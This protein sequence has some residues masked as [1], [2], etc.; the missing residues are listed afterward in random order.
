MYLSR[1]EHMLFD[2]AHCQLDKAYSRDLKRSAAR[3]RCERPGQLGRNLPNRGPSMLRLVHPAPVGQGSRALGHR[4]ASCPSL[5]AHEWHHFH[6]ALQNSPPPLLG[7]KLA[8]DSRL[9]RGCSEVR[10]QILKSLRDRRM[11]RRD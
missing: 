5:I 9:W 8:I 4:R 1:V 3:E 6:T 7:R 2:F 10:T 11:A